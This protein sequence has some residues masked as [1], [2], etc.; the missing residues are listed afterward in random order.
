MN[1][2]LAGIGAR[3]VYIGEQTGD[4]LLLLLRSLLDCRWA[5][6]RP[7]RIAAQMKRVGNETLLIASGI[8]LFI[9]MVLAL[10][11]GSALKRF[12]A[13]STIS[14]IIS[15]SMIKELGPVITA[16]LLAGR[17]GAAI[18]AEIGTMQVN[19]EI[20]ALHTLGISPVRYLA[21]PR[22]IACTTMLP[23]LVIYASAV[24]IAGGGLVANSYFDI[25]WRAYFDGAFN[26]LD[27]MDL[28]ESILKSALFG[29]IIA[30]V[31]CQRGFQTRGG[32]EGVGR[33]ITSCVVTCFVCI[34][35]A[36]YFVTRFLL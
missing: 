28:V 11:I 2:L 13:E 10:Q 9:G 20:D 25:G 1:G 4:S 33:A 16:L 35:I 22:F 12:E 17:I 18:A 34:I 31:A 27:A 14:A 26:T 30:T 15:Y 21:M 8:S 19:E 7:R 5:F 3:I 29:A 6:A 36:D 32:A 24:G 23:I